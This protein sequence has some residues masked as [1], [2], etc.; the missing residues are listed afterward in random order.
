MNYGF[1][2]KTEPVTTNFLMGPNG[3]LWWIAILFLIIAF[4]MFGLIVGEMARE[5]RCREFVGNSYI[6]DSPLCYQVVEGTPYYVDVDMEIKLNKL[7]EK[8]K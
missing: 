2:E 8:S 6:Y 7:K 4:G 3:P 5:T 1:D